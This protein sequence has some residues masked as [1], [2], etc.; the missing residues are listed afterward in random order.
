MEDK[1]VNFLLLL[2][3]STFQKVTVAFLLTSIKIAINAHMHAL[4]SAA[5]IIYQVPLNS[6]SSLPLVQH[7]SKVKSYIIILIARAPIS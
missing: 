2:F 3:H 6:H 1:A 5:V 7:F 4:Y